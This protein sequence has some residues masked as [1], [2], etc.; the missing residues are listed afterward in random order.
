MAT[1]SSNELLKIDMSFDAELGIDF[2]YVYQ[3][4]INHYRSM[5]HFDD[6]Y[7]NYKVEVTLN[8]VNLGAEGM[9]KYLEAMRLDVDLSILSDLPE[10]GILRDIELFDFLL[11]NR[12]SF[13]HKGQLLNP[14]IKEVW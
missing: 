8:N 10:L 7:E 14:P 12:I 11:R 13:L 5:A 1:M 6:I 4:A 2:M 9:S 3:S